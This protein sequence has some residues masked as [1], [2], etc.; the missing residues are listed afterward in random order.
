MEELK[1]QLELKLEV[2]KNETENSNKIILDLLT[3]VFPQV[4]RTRLDSR[5]VKI[6]TAKYNSQ[7]GH[8]ITIFNNYD[9]RVHEFQFKPQLSWFS[10]NAEQ[11]DTDM[12]NYL[13]VLG[14]VAK[15]MKNE[16]SFLFNVIKGNLSH[17]YTLEDEVY[18]LRFE[19]DKIEA[20]IKK[21]QDAE[22]K[23]EFV[24]NF[25]EGNL[26]FKKNNFGNS[27]DIVLIKKIA[28]KTV[29]VSSYDALNE[30]TIQ[31]LQVGSYNRRIKKEDIYN[32]LK[33]HSLISFDDLFLII[34]N[35]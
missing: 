8:E 28:Q 14:F 10:S 27:Y 29:T 7:F 19:I 1:K 20:D 18:K 26:Y 2:L 16:N 11:K 34:N 32:S 4:I 35:N 9:C 3:A 22:K 30:R 6:I 13:E 31:H 15:E 23:D 24:N 5:T 25:K 33:S 12:L 17:Q 21:K